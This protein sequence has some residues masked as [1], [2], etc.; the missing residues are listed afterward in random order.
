[1]LRVYVGFIVQLW[2]A[3]IRDYF[4]SAQSLTTSTLVPATVILMTRY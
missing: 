3:L 1:M 2:F 4:R